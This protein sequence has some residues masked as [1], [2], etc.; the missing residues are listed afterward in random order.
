MK[1]KAKEENASDPAPLNVVS[2]LPRTG[3][4]IN[5]PLYMTL[6]AAA[7]ILDV[8]LRYARKRREQWQE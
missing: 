4:H 5:L 8:S 7:L 1:R 2:V 3:D 6:A